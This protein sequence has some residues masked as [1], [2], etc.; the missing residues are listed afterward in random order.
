MPSPFDE[1]FSLT[2]EGGRPLSSGFELGERITLLIERTELG[3]VATSEQA[4]VY[5]EGANV[6]S[7][8]VDFFADLVEHRRWL[9]ADRERL[10]PGMLEEL[11]QVRRLVRPA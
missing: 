5:G 1:P 7:T 6:T 9:E 2:F 11:A 4:P 3:F 10:A 8:A